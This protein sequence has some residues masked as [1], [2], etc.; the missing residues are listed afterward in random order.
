MKT[1]RPFTKQDW[2]AFSGCETD[3]PFIAE[4]DEECS[5]LV[6]DG[7]VLQLICDRDNWWSR[8]FDKPIVALHVA[9]AICAAADPVELGKALLDEVTGTEP[10]SP[11]IED[12][13]VLE[14]A[15]K[16]VEREC[17]AGG[18]RWM[19]KRAAELRASAASAPDWADELAKEL[20]SGCYGT[21]HIDL[22]AFLRE[23]LG[24]VV[25]A[26]EMIEHEDTDD[27]AALAGA[28]RRKLE[29]K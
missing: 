1:L 17:P 14:R 4:L 2:D 19:S 22:A 12:A 6:L 29:G 26:M 16:I 25:D 3:N 20:L 18:H 10:Y 11:A 27:P 13:D 28:A 24:P 5:V 15:A 23:S 8:T 21:G 9:H 7:N